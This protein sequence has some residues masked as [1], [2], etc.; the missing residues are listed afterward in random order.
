MVEPAFEFTQ[1]LAGEITQPHH[2]ESQAY[3]S[4]RRLTLPAQS[5]RHR[6]RLL[7]GHHQG[8]HEGSTRLPR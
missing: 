8:Y 1:H 5:R 7:I 3:P 4:I 2:Q 6:A